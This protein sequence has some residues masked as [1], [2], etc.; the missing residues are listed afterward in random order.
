M[1]AIDKLVPSQKVRSKPTATP[2]MTARRLFAALIASIVVGVAGCGSG[3]SVPVDSNAQAPVISTSSLPAGTAGS[4]YSV[5]IAVTSGVKPYTFSVDSGVLPQG[6]TLSSAGVLAGMPS[7]AGNYSFTI[8]VSDALKFHTSTPFTLKVTSALTI[9]TPPLGP[10]M[11]GLPYDAQFYASLGVPPYTFAVTSGALPSGLTM[12]PAGALSG[13]ATAA[14]TFNFTITVTDAVSQKSSTAYTLVIAPPPNPLTITTPPLG[15]GYV[16]NEYDAQFYAANGIPPYVFSVSSG[17]LPPG[18]TLSLNGALRGVPT[19]T[20]TSIFTVTVVD[21]VGQ[22]ASTSYTLLIAGGSSPLTLANATLPS[23]VPNAPYMASLPIAGGHAPYTVTM[24]N[25]SLPTGI[26]LSAAGALSGTATVTGTSTFSVSVADSS[27]PQQTVSATLTLKVTTGTMA[28]VT[29]NTA[30]VLATVP[31]TYFGLHTSVYDDKLSDAAALP[32]LL[33]TTGVTM[34][35][36]PGGSYSDRYHWAQNSISNIQASTAPACAVIQGEKYLATNADFGH[37]VK[38]LQASGAQAIITVNYGTSVADASASITAGSTGTLNRCSEPNTAGQPQEAA[39]WVAYA[40]G[41]VSSTQKIGLDA[42]GFDWKTVGFWASLRAASPLAVDDG[43]NFLRLGLAAPIG[44]QYWEIGNE[45]YYNGFDGNR[46]PETDLHAPYIY[47]NGYGGGPFNS[48]DQVAALSPAAYGTNAITFV[49]A[50]K[51]VD[52]TIKI[53][54]D[55]SSPVVDPIALTF[56]PSLMKAICAGTT[57]DLALI[58]YYPGTYEDMQASEMLSLPQSDLPTLVSGIKTQLAQYCPANASAVQVFLTETSPNGTVDAS[59]P[60]AVQGLYALNI[61]MAGLK[62]GL[63]NVDWLELHNGTYL[64][65]TEMPGPVYYSM[66]L[67]HLMAAVGDTEVAAASDTPSVVTYATLKANG[68][69]GVLLINADASTPAVVKVTVSGSTLGASAT[70]YSYGV[71][72]TQNAT[73]LVG[74][75]F[76]VS[77][78]TFTV[79]V[80]AYTAVEVLVP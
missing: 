55:M 61:Y 20:G 75:P 49:Q 65:E 5:T 44:I 56:N 73:T 13:T 19:S 12:T 32:A 39:A 79:T 10:G 18:F 66:Q 43:Y 27:T 67:G 45:V 7:V 15:P 71:A 22:Q 48:R 77:G 40:N 23:A 52:P 74:T 11:A 64:D 26:T 34:L 78:S 47:P 36:Y 14:G 30:T 24:T 9:T 21:A 69:K 70:M 31:Q 50:M 3:T 72:T 41:S 63:K 29:V 54:V 35:R 17:A 8:G 42:A 28:N 1:S 53:G 76:N 51:A 4:A 62:A 6:F 38:T 68:Q 46:N 80:P 33:H 37:F 58:H 16:A 59:V 60:F 25:G 57:F 2:S